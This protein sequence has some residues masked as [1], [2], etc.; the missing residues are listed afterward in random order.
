MTRSARENPVEV[1]FHPSEYRAVERATMRQY[2][3]FISLLA[4]LLAASPSQGFDNIEADAAYNGKI[5]EK[6]ASVEVE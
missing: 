1:V 6:F 2:L 5:K 4:G 3:F